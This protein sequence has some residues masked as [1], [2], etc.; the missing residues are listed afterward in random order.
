MLY[1]QIT[2]PPELYSSLPHYLE[3][4]CCCLQSLIAIQVLG[5]GDMPLKDSSVEEHTTAFVHGRH[6]GCTKREGEGRAGHHFVLYRAPL[7]Y[8]CPRDKTP[9]RETHTSWGWSKTLTSPPWCM[10]L[11]QPLHELESLLRRRC[12]NE[13][14]H[15]IALGSDNSATAD[16]CWF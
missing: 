13:Q 1:S 8:S 6:H 9:Q 2:S 7:L 3:V 4:A 12:F 11:P 5:F 10:C 16:N 15:K 14:V